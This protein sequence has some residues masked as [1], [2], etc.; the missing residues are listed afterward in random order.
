VSSAAA[1]EQQSSKAAPL[2]PWGIRASQ[3]LAAERT[4]QRARKTCRP[5][6]QQQP[7]P[8]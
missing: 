7:S 3:L 2:R 8:P 4:Q 1:I 5:A 6:Q